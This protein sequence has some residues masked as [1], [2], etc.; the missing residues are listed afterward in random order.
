VYLAVG[1]DNARYIAEAMSRKGDLVEAV[2]IPGWKATSVGVQI[3]EGRLLEAISRRKPD[4]VILECLDDNIYFGLLE[5]GS[6]I[7]AKA[8]EDGIELVEG[9]LVV[10]KKDSTELLFKR[11]EPLWEAMAHG[12]G[13]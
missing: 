2:V 10:G 3:L 1:G 5:D 11:L 7:L 12:Q 8:G 4:V 6:S 13:L 9:R